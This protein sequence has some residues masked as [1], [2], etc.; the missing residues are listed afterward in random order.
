[1]CR[2]ANKCQGPSKA[3]VTFSLSENMKETSSPTR[4]V[5]SNTKAT[6]QGVKQQLPVKAKAQILKIKPPRL[7]PRSNRSAALDIIFR[8]SQSDFKASQKGGF[9]LAPRFTNDFPDHTTC[10]SNFP[11]KE[12]RNFN[13]I[14]TTHSLFLTPRSNE[15]RMGSPPPL[16]MPSDAVMDFDNSFPEAV[17]LPSF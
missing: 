13:I 5:E 17:W 12:D 2:A 15:V 6:S 4:A 11:I 16:L 3:S 10:S 8:G 9:V 1:M 14:G 7:N